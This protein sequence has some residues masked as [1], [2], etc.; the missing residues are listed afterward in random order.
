MATQPKLTLSTAALETATVTFHTNDDD[1]D[2]D[3]HVTI[4]VRDQVGNVA[5]RISD[6]F[7]H[8]TDHSDS[9]PF[10]L[11]VEDPASQQDL[12]AG[13]VTIRIDPVGNDTWRFNFFLEM[14][15]ADGSR[16]SA[17]ADGLELNDERQ[18]QTFG[19]Q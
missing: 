18:E 16:L 5:A 3:T 15:F 13:S 14:I 4:T 9:G 6:D 7:G 11:Q 10:N 2:H 12:K 1:K 19:I 8:F 17:G